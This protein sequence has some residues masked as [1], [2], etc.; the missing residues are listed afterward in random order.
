MLAQR[1]IPPGSIADTRQN[2]SASVHSFFF[3]VCPPY[4]SF[5]FRLAVLRFAARAVLFSAFGSVY[6]IHSIGAM[7]AERKRI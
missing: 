7:P 4:V 6:H 3:I 1:G 5:L 2:A